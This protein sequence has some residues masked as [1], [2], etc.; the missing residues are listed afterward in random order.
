MAAR[1]KGSSK[2]ESASETDGYRPTVEGETAIDQ[3]AL[4]LDILI[5]DEHILYETKPLLWLQLGRVFPSIII[6]LVITLFAER[7]PLGFVDTISDQISIQIAVA[8][9]HTVIRW[10]GLAIVFLGLL[11]VM[12]KCLRWRSTAYTATNLR[13]LNRKGIIAKNYTATSLS[14]IETLYLHVP[15]LGRVFDYGTIRMITASGGSMET[16]WQDLKEPK[17]VHHMLNQITEQY[18]RDADQPG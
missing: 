7:I 13:I 11:G 14:K 4:P 17:K 15:V 12:I 2:E 5:D 16:Q 8:D 6:G 9:V 1:G 18:R 10:L 3:G